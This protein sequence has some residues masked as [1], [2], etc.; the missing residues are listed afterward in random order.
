M[1]DSFDPYERGNPLQGDDLDD[2]IN[3]PSGIGPLAYTWEDKS[4]RLLYDL[5]RMLREEREK[6]K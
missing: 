6:N 5:V 1:T 2:Y 4:H 3:A